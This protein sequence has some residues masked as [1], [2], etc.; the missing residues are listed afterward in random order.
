MAFTWHGL[1][2]LRAAGTFLFFSFC[3]F[4]CLFGDVRG[5]LGI[6]FG[7]EARRERGGVAVVEKR[8]EATG[9]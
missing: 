6:Y 1:S 2:R 4:A 9:I 5:G 3:W 8:R 7:R